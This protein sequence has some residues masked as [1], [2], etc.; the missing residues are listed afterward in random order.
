MDHGSR[1]LS[2]E[3]HC[4]AGPRTQMEIEWALGG[5]Q[6]GGG[7]GARKGGR[8]ERTK[9]RRKGE[10]TTAKTETRSGTGSRKSAAA[11]RYI[12]RLGVVV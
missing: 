3:M 2:L 10:R 1:E 9:E 12:L 4:T 11:F 6:G 7:R 5:V 8:N